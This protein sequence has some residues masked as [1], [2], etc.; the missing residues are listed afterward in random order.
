MGIKFALKIWFKI[1]KTRQSAIMLPS[2]YDT[3]NHTPCGCLK[4]CVD[5]ILFKQKRD[6]SGKIMK[7][8]WRSECRYSVQHCKQ[9]LAA[10]DST[11]SSPYN[12]SPNDLILRYTVGIDIFV[13]SLHHAM[14]LLLVY[15]KYFLELLCHGNFDSNF[16]LTQN[17]I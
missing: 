8:Q 9:Q 14:H 13:C 10:I 12:C 16:R 5:H 11:K 2:A 17:D 1:L 3:V 7:Y 15:C 4:L 6:S